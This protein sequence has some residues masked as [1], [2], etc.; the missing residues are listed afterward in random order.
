MT[1]KK[2]NNADAGDS[3]HF[4]G[5]DLDKISDVL[6]GV[7]SDTVTLH[8]TVANGINQYLKKFGNK[9]WGVVT[10]TGGTGGDP[11]GIFVNCVTSTATANGIGMDT[12]HGPYRH[13]DTA[14][15]TPSGAGAVMSQVV[16]MRAFNPRFRCKFSLGQTADVRCWFGFWT[17]ASVY[18]TTDDAFGGGFA[19]FCL[20]IRANDTVW[21]IAHNDNSGATVYAAVAGNPAVDTAVHV[22]EIFAD[23]ANTR[24]GYSFDGG[25]ITYISTDIPASTASLDFI[26]S[27]QNSAAAIKVLNLYWVE[28]ESDK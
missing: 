26:A 2:V 10:Y 8:D 17:R 23:E 12:T 11:S 6:S 14:A 1:W 13:F 7:N 15:T 4:G 27:I 22:I 28:M 19:G 3:T 9:K 21:Q 25:T 24:F 5:N 18:P 20:G 16:T